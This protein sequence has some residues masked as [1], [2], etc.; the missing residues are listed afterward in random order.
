MDDD[1]I[2]F[3]ECSE[4]GSPF[5]IEL[6]RD[7]HILDYARNHSCPS[8]SKVPAAPPETPWHHIT[9]FRSVKKSR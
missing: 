1:G 7:G 3:L 8:C 5:D 2:W 4:C 9:G 6:T